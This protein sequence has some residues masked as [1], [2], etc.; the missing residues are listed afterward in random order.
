ML[1]HY[2]NYWRCLIFTANLEIPIIPKC[3]IISRLE[4][5]Y[6]NYWYL[7]VFESIVIVVS[8]DHLSIIFLLL[9]IRLRWY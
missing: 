4:Y 9:L 8:I 5:G 3:Y 1:R 2:D 7:G 6:F